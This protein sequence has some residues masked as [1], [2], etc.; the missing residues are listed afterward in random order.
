M[1]F[2][3]L[4][5]NL[6]C[7]G[8]IFRSK[9]DEELLVRI[10]FYSG[11]GYDLRACGCADAMHDVVHVKQTHDLVLALFCFFF[12]V[13]LVDI[14][15]IWIIRRNV[16][17]DSVQILRL[18]NIQANVWLNM[19]INVNIFYKYTC[20][21]TGTD[22]KIGDEFYKFKSVDESDFFFIQ[23]RANK[24]VFAGALDGSKSTCNYIY[25]SGA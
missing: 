4:F 13:F 17:Y 20:S 14:T 9:S 23:S 7:C 16:K 19:N 6:L 22:L 24:N 21:C 8:R 18:K 5:G 1:C 10:F 25:L 15:D 2:Q 3:K 11:V 12:G